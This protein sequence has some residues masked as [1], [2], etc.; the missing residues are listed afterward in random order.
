MLIRRE[1]VWAMPALSRCE[2]AIGRSSASR[3]R[4]LGG[5][6]P[7]V[8]GSGNEG[9][10]MFSSRWRRPSSCRVCAYVPVDSQS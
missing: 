4:L 2:Y 9:L 6:V 3:Y 1:I 5:V 10:M 8:P 7:I